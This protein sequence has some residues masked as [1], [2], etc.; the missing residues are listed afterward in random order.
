VTAEPTDGPELGRSES[1]EGSGGAASDG[2]VHARQSRREAVGA[3]AARRV[4]VPVRRRP[5][6]LRGG[7]RVWCVRTRRYVTFME[8]RRRICPV[9]NRLGRRYSKRRWSMVHICTLV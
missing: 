1:R 4:R 6:A 7:G 2:H 3:P 5:V 8:E 9:Y